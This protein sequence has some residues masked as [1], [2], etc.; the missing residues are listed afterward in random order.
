MC[1][2]DSSWQAA[3]RIIR[4]LNSKARKQDNVASKMF[5]HHNCAKLYPAYLVQAGYV[6]RP[7]T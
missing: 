1:K 7:N 2:E 5:R 3:Q 4:Q 6:R